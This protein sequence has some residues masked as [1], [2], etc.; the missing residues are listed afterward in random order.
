MSFYN[1]GNQLKLFY[2]LEDTFLNDKVNKYWTSGLNDVYVPIKRITL[3]QI[4][5]HAQ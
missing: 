5:T 3:K 4:K 1:K 2:Y